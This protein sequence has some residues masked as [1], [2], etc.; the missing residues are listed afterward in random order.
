[1]KIKSAICLFVLASGTSLL[2]ADNMTT[3]GWNNTNGEGTN[4]WSRINDQ[5]N[6]RQGHHNDENDYSRERGNSAAQT[7][8][9]STNQ[10]NGNASGAWSRE[11]NQ[12]SRW[13]GHHDD[14]NDYGRTNNWNGGMSHTNMWREGTNN[15]HE[16]MTGRTNYP[17][18]K[19]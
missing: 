1:M 5:Q 17:S 2:A 14:A 7:S 10:Y 18:R 3:N 6:R 19:Y 9:M 12:E 11:N 4:V 16:G 8:Q 15:W 13:Q